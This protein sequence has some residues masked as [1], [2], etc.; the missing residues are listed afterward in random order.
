[1]GRRV[2]RFAKPDQDIGPVD[3]PRG[4]LDSDRLDL[5]VGLTQPGRVGEQDRH[6][7]E[8]QR[9]LDMIARGPR[10]SGNDRAL[11]SGYCIDKAGLSCVRRTCDHHA[12]AVLQGLDPRP[13][14]PLA[15]LAGKQR[16]IAQQGGINRFVI[17][18][19]VDRAFGP[20]RQGKQPLLPRGDLLPETPLRQDKRR[21]ALRLGLGLDEVREAFSFG[22]VDP[23]VLECAAGELAGLR[24]SQPLNASQC[25]QHRVDHRPSAMGVEL[26]HILP[27]RARRA[28]E[29]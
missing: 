3:Q 6:A 13:L 19:I 27:G 14:Q 4:A 18:V 2:A 25:G 23:A 5:I 17:F 11:L 9:H 7:T 1:V 28:V 20:G 8:R 22:Q 29:T 12:H 10:H 15:E 16:A 26:D 24:L 21:L